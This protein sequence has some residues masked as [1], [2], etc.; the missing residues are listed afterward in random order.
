MNINQTDI[1][2]EQKYE[3]TGTCVGGAVLNTH[4]A[5]YVCIATHTN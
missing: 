3:C 5:F 2:F 1:F 4:F